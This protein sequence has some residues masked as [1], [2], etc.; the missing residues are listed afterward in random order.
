M[1]LKTKHQH[2][3][4][5]MGYQAQEA[6]SVQEYLPLSTPT[7]FQQKDLPAPPFSVFVS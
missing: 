5:E 6:I 3:L 1:S 2:T 7:E 4:R